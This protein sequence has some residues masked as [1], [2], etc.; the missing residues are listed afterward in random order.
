[1]KSKA[2]R[3]D[4]CCLMLQKQI[5]STDSI[6]GKWIFLSDFSRASVFQTA[7]IRQVSYWANIS[8]KLFSFIRHV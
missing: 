8:T 5:L 7:S 2:Q 6:T 3:T 4:V 1:M